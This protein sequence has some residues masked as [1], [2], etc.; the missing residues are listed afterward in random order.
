MY[1]PLG[2]LK[3]TANN[4][5]ATVIYPTVALLYFTLLYS[6]QNLPEDDTVVQNICSDKRLYCCV[7]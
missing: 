6:L 2:I 3:F 7:C 5:I 4:S 1:V